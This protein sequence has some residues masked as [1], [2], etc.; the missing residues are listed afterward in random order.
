MTN[1]SSSASP[2]LRFAAAHLNNRRKI[3]ADKTRLQGK[4]QQPQQ[5]PSEIQVASTAGPSVRVST[6]QRQAQG[7][8]QP[9]STS[10]DGLD[11]PQPDHDE[12]T[13]Q[14]H[15]VEDDEQDDDDD[16]FQTGPDVVKNVVTISSQQ[17]AESNKE[18]EVQPTLS[19]VDGGKRK[20]LIDAQPNARR[21]PSISQDSSLEDQDNQSSD[22]SEDE[23]IQQSRL[24]PTTTSSLT[25]RN[26]AKRRATAARMTQQSPPKRDRAQADPRSSHTRD[27]QPRVLQEQQI[28]QS[29]AQNYYV[30]SAAAK[31]RRP[32]GRSKATQSRTPWSEE[33]IEQLI[34]L[35]GLYGASYAQIKKRDDE[36]GGLLE[37]RDQVALKDKARNMKLDYLK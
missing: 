18:N 28:P 32:P 31:M 3:T 37:N 11:Q 14:R 17:Q 33:E 26:T 1:R 15:E 12:D 10:L 7:P 13:W 23:G 22:L 5:N 8:Q 20:R 21:V 9:S 19:R 24:P 30:V 16:A 4:L 36:Q 25:R 27:S 6:P 35:I 34:S 29:Q 2:K